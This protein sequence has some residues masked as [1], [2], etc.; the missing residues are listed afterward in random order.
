MA[1]TNAPHQPTGNDAGR[2]GQPD[3]TPEEVKN[4]K[5]PNPNSPGPKMPTPAEQER[6]KNT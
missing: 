6:A 5:L 1:T 3:P 4:S 2:P